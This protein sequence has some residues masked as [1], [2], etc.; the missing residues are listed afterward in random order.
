M[1]FVDVVREQERRLFDIFSLFHVGIV[2]V[3]I[4]VID[5]VRM[6]DEVIIYG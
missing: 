6:F 5:I 1:M 4:G 2:G 3:I